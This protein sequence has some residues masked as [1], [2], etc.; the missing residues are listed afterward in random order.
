LIF[1]K[2]AKRFVLRA[3][4]HLNWRFAS[5]V[6]KLLWEYRGHALIVLAITV[7]AEIVALWPVSLL[8]QFV[9]GL[10]SG[11]V[12]A[13]VWLFMGASMLAP[14]VTRIN[15]IYSNKMFYEMDQ[16]KWVQLTLEVAEDGRCAGDAEK[17]GAANTRIINA[18][19][20]V[21]NVAFYM[22]RSIAP[23]VVK[24]VVV[25]GSLLAYNRLLAGAYL[26]T[27]AVPTVM[28]VAFNNKLR[29][30]R[31]S[32][33]SIMSEA[34]GAG[35]RVMSEPQNQSAW[36]KFQRIVTE[37][38]NIIFSL[39]AKHQIFLNLREIALVGSQFLIVF[40]AL[41]MREQIGL[42]PGDFTKIIGY[43]GQVATAFIGV[44]SVVDSIISQTRAYHV[45]LQ[46]H[47]R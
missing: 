11:D 23:I 17:A 4:T 38:K 42:T 15:I 40:I 21:A 13:T 8:G 46:A 24:I 7:V 35:I 10:Q 39:L 33:Y 32:Q 41:G 22:V 29:V 34:S 14:I 2:L 30:L 16:Q 18:V 6:A 28:T 31:D 27:L 12:G 43:T 9:D 45:Y 19:G 20:A 37:R 3:Q 25:S 47:G 1:K 5:D 26:A 36:E 44:A